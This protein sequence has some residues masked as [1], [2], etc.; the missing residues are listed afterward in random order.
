MISRPVEVM[1]VT[2]RRALLPLAF[3]ALLLAS[4]GSPATAGHWRTYYGDWWSTHQAIYEMNNRIALLEANP[5]TDDG[6]RAPIINRTRAQI[7]RLHAT[8]GPAQWQWTT[9]CCYSRPP[10]YIGWSSHRRQPH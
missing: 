5:E 2:I 6:Y 8:L 9:P 7:R 4:A 1:A 10:I 3:V